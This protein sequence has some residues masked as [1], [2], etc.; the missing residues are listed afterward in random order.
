MS[1]TD[2]ISSL[3]DPKLVHPGLTLMHTTLRV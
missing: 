1:Y 3:L 2:L